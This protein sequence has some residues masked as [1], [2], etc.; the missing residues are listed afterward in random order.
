MCITPSNISNIG[1]VAC[2]NCWQCRSNRVNDYVGRCIAEAHTSKLTLAVTLTYGQGDIDRSAALYYPDFQKF[3]KKLRRAGYT[4]RYIVAGEYGSQKGRAHWHAILFFSGEKIPDIGELALNKRIQWKYWAEGF[5]WIE[6]PDYGAFRYVLKYTLKQEHGDVNVGHL[7]MSKKPPL[8]YEYFQQRVQRYVD[9]GLAPQ[10][11][12]YTFDDEFDS[13]GKRREFM[14][15]G[16]TREN[17]INQFIAL[18]QKTYVKPLPES[19]IIEEHID[20]LVEDDPAYAWERFIIDLTSKASPYWS[21]ETSSQIVKAV[22][23]NG[24]CITKNV[25]NKWHYLKLNDKGD[26]TWRRELF[27][28]AQIRMAVKGELTRPKKMAISY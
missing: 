1:L 25:F 15:Q 2:R 9:Q 22:A 12:K 24:G 16:V 21:G 18:W 20:K 6:E 23:V 28:R 3:M 27:D 4:V 26:I 5:S 8:G 7:A 10:S 19:E 14:M 13:G 17:F 11:Y